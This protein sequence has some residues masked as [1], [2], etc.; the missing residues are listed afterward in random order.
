ML[1]NLDVS[2]ICQSNRSKPEQLPERL[3][4]IKNASRIID[5]YIAENIDKF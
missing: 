2:L 4:Q 1:Q 5:D 3:D